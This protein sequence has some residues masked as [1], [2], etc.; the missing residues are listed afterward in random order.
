MAN[1][2]IRNAI[3][4]GLVPIIIFAVAFNALS[5]LY[6]G[7]IKEAKIETLVEYL[8]QRSTFLESAI[9]KQIAQLDFNCQSDDMKVLRDPRYYN[10][11]IRFIGMT[12]EDGDSCS[13]V[14]MP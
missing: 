5:N 14:G 10:R 12:T 2:T 9:T 13:S 6:V 7:H 3:L 8:N 1:K 4:I 11:Y